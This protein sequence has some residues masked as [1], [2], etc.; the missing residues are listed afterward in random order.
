M[1]LGGVCVEYGGVLSR[2]VRS[3]LVHGPTYRVVSVVITII[4][5]IAVAAYRHRH[6]SAPPADVGGS[7]F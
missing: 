2:V 3:K 1:Y 5:R 7:T 6:S 4:I